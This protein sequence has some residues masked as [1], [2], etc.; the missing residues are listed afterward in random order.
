VTEPGVEDAV[1]VIEHALE[2]EP[3]LDRVHAEESPKLPPAPPSLH[4]TV[5]VGVI[6]E[7]LVSVTVAL[8][9]IMP[10]VLADAGL[11]VTPVVV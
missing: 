1:Y 7:P 4:V 2:E 8:N 6:G 11:G 10:P 5:P 3:R 9:V